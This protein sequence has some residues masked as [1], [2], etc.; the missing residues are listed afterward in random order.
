MRGP[1]AYGLR[2]PS[3]GMPSG[4]E[5]PETLEARAREVVYRLLAVRARSRREVESRLHEKGFPHGIVKRTL[6]RLDGL[7]FLNEREFAR[8]LARARLARRPMGEWALRFELRRRG[9]EGEVVEE[10]LE[11]AYAE[12]TPES[13]ARRAAEKKLR[14]LRG[15]SPRAAGGKLEIFLLRRGFKKELAHKTAQSFMGGE[16][17]DDEPAGLVDNSYPP[18]ALL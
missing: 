10:A 15:L 5:A 11:A 14:S 1:R 2:I 17:F 12:E 6:D 9:L 16:I 3:K 7:G 13:L 8:A 4:E 18:E